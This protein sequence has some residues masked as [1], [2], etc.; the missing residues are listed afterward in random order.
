[1]IRTAQRLPRQ[2]WEV[3]Q[4]RKDQNVKNLS[5]GSDHLLMQITLLKWIVFFI[6]INTES[7]LKSIVHKH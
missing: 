6:V 4:I 3:W 1:M 7:L 2:A 5:N